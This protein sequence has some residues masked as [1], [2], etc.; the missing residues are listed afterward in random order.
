MREMNIGMPVRGLKKGGGDM[1]NLCLVN[2][3]V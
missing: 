2:V 3:R 1:S